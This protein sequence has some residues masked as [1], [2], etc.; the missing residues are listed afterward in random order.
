MDSIHQV[1][2]QPQPVNKEKVKKLLRIAIIL[3]IITSIEFF[4]ALA[5]PKGILLTVVFITLTLVKAFYIVSEFMHLKYEAKVMIW[6]I[7]LP[8]ML[9]FWLIIALITEGGSVFRAK[10][11]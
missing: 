5:M 2:V 10:F 4:L 8:M 6:S 1:S 7:I 9:V 3:A 11:F